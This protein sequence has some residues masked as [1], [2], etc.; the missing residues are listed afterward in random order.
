[1]IVLIEGPDC[2]GKTTLCENFIKNGFDYIHLGKLKFIEKEYNNLINKLNPKNNVIIDRAVLSNLIY[3][4]IFSDTKCLS[5][6]L[7][8][9][10][11]SL[12]SIII[13]ALP[14]DKKRYLNNF[15]KIKTMRDEEYLTMDK[16]YDMFEDII[17]TTN[18]M[19]K[20]IIRYDMFKDTFKD[21]SNKIK[22]IIKC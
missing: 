18:K 20:P 4:K 5:K 15:N 11:L 14:L 22:E 9:K 6:K 2:A 21:V 7:K 16:I 3:S 10:F 13:I 8:D 19:H 17:T 12:I 1:M